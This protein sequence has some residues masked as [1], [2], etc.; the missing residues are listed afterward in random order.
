MRPGACSAGGL[1]PGR[2]RKD[3]ALGGR[4]VLGILGKAV[5][6]RGGPRS[7]GTACSDA[8][9]PPD[10]GGPNPA[11]RGRRPSSAAA[12]DS[13]RDSARRPAPDLTKP[14]SEAANQRRAGRVGRATGLYS[15][16][17]GG[18]RL[19]SPAPL[20]QLRF[21]PARCSLRVDQST[22]A[23]SRTVAVTARAQG[24]LGAGQLQH[25]RG[26]RLP[27]QVQK[28]TGGPG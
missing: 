6:R 26:L 9:S 22:S 20:A 16:G 5:P 1:P 25:V 18:L 11:A 23:A 15:L 2:G 24:T 21:S 10:P 7:R 27:A 14:G 19:L 13:E 3:R 28:K 8:P 4:P 17:S 12:A